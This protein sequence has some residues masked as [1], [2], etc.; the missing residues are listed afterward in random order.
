MARLKWSTA[1]LGTGKLSQY[2]NRGLENFA[3]VVT[4]A[5]QASFDFNTKFF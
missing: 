1:D 2:L 5:K 4:V 3:I